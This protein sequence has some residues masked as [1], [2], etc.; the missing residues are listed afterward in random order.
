LLLPNAN[1]M[2]GV[3]YANASILSVCSRTADRYASPEQ[4]RLSL[5]FPRFKA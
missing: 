3:R 5:D 1:A 2:V 4:L